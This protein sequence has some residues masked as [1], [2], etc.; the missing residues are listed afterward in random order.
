MYDLSQLITDVGDTRGLSDTQ[1][2]EKQEQMQSWD[3]FTHGISDDEPEKQKQPHG[4]SLEA[5]PR[6]AGLLRRGGVI[7]RRGGV[8]LRRGGVILW[9]GIRVPLFRLIVLCALPLIFALSVG[10]LLHDTVHFGIHV[11]GTVK[12]SVFSLMCVIFF[13]CFHSRVLL[14]AVAWAIFYCVTTLLM[15]ALAGNYPVCIYL[16]Y[17]FIIWCKPDIENIV[18]C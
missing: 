6:K 8:I 12:C 3:T 14:T 15:T 17:S 11:S 16:S 9:R 5:Q 10:Y 7:L 2:L 4:Q 1:V 18:C 13:Y